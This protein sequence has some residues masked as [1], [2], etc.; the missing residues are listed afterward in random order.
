MASSFASEIIRLHGHPKVIV[1]DCDPKLMDSLL[2]KIHRFQRKPLSMSTAYH[3]QMDG[4]SEALS[5]CC[6]QY[7]R[8]FMGDSP[9]EWTPIPCAEY[10]YNTTY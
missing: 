10:W 5:K 3:L 4:Q 6:E 8:C 9:H 7:F 1:T 2:E